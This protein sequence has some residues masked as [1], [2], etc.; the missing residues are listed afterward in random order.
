MKRIPIATALIV[1]LALPAHAATST[2]GDATP[3]F[4]ESSTCG[5]YGMRGPLS[6]SNR[7]GDR[8]YGPFADYFGRNYGQ[9]SA[10]IVDW[11]EPS[12]HLF[13][14]HTRALAAFQ[15]AAQRI[16]AS[17]AGYTVRTG[18]GWTW[19]NIAGSNQMSHH[20]VANAVDV[21][22]P[23]NPVTSGALITDMPRAYREAWTAAGFCWGGSWRFSKDSMHYSWR[24]P[25]AVAGQM[26]R[27]VPFAPLTPTA[28]FTTL[29]LDAPSAIGSGALAMSGKR[30]DGADDLYGLA[31]VGGQW[32][33]QV[34][35][36][37]AR[38]GVLGVRWTSGAPAGG[39]PYFADADGDGRAD[40]WRF[41]TSGPTITANVYYDRSRFRTVGKQVTTG[42]AWSADA[43]LGMALYDTADWVPDLYVFRRNTSRVE[44]YSS[45][46]GYQQMVHSST[47]A[48]PIGSS[49][50]VLADRNVDGRTDIW[51]VGSG[52]NAL[53]DVVLWSNGYGGSPQRVNTS[54]TVPSGAS[55][56][57]GDFDGDGRVDLYVVSGGRVSIWLGGA[58]DRAIADLGDWFTTAGP[59]TFDA[60]P[61]CVGECD[62][63]GYVDPGG[64][65]RLAHEV[66]WAPF[67]SSYFYGNP[68]DS[69]FMGDWDCDG[70]DTPGLYRRSD[71][72]VYLR[73][74]NTEGVADIKFFFGNPSDIPIPGDFD[75]DGC[76]TVSI[77]RPA[78]QRFYV[79]DRLGAGDAGLGAAERSFVFGDPGDKP[80]VGDFDGNG[81]DEVGLH[82][83]STGRVYFRFSLTSGI[84]DRDFIYGD[85]GDF[86]L[87]GDWDGDGTDTPAIFRPSDGNWYIR[88]ANTQGN[89]NHVIPFGLADRGLLPVVGRN[90]FAS[91]LSPLSGVD[92]T[93]GD[94]DLLPSETD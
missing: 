45:A 93:P 59:N 1:A 21:N 19:R 41:N 73:N 72:Y 12:G 61:L 25:A 36:A 10:S 38:F 3:N 76:D 80:F 92:T 87:A 51:L 69:P 71:G 48:A 20:A 56:L 8:L 47:L 77:Y 52:S 35:G 22:P 37:G 23:Q 50:I 94:S 6:P 66:A 62:Q 84:A 40:L 5:V 2:A 75:G 30:R 31:A 43:E 13:R 17:G 18:A 86:L 33:V 15:N 82:R 58:P 27:A 26:A 67:E 79:I 57:P 24:G 85:P 60:G 29:A 55:V 49:R 91:G 74:S 7:I 53:V 54:M 16:R 88:L 90:G 39:V 9:V 70:I 65:W 81:L 89:A 42:A 11:V 63:V 46:S 64:S 28:N 68:A 14:V 44:V 4:T 83:E 34:A 32:Q 78:E